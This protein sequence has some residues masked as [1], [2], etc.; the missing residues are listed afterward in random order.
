M[1]RTE[2]DSKSEVQKIE[3]VKALQHSALVAVDMLHKLLS[4][5]AED[6]HPG[7]YQ[8]LASLTYSIDLDVFKLMLAV[9]ESTDDKSVHPS[10]A[11][12]FV[13]KA[14]EHGY[15]VPDYISKAA[16]DE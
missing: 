1:A 14:K 2:K 16:K 15:K 10:E 8:Q 4:L 5:K 13:A 7:M 6:L 11:Q 3:E 12:V 9:A